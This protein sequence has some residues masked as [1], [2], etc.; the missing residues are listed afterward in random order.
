[1]NT[2]SFP[3]YAGALT[4][5]NPYSGDSARSQEHWLNYLSNA[6]L[7]KYIADSAGCFLERTSNGNRL[8]ALA[9]EQL[10][11]LNQGVQHLNQGVHQSNQL[12]AGIYSRLVRQFEE[13]RISNVLLENIAEL[14]N[15]PDGEK[16]RHAD[17]KWGLKFCKDAIRDSDLYQDALKYLQCA[18]V[19][20]PEDYFVLRQIGIL[21]LHVPALVNLQMAADY[22]T[23]AG[24]YASVDSQ[25]DAVRIG[26]VLAKSVLRRFS[27]QPDTTA[28][29]IALFAAETYLHAAVAQYAQGN[30][31]KAVDLIKKASRL[32]PECPN[33][34]FFQAKYLAAL[35]END[36]ALAVL[37]SFRDV[38]N[39]L[40][41][42]VSVDLD[43]RGSVAALWLE[44]LPRLAKRW[45]DQ[46]I[47][48][49]QPVM[50]HA[51][52]DDMQIEFFSK[53]GTVVAW[54]NDGQATVPAGLSGVVAIAARGFHTVALK[55]DG[56]VVAWGSNNSGQTTVPAGLS[57]VVAI[58]VGRLYTVALKQDG[59][60]V[61]WG[62]N[63]DGQATVP[64]GLSGVVAIAVGGFHTVALKQ[65]GTVVAWGNND[66]G[67]TTVPADL[68]GVEAIAATG[69]H[70]VALKQDRT[71]V[72]WGFNDDGQT[73][74]PADLSG[75]VAIAATG[76]HIV[77]LKQDRTVVAWGYNGSG[78][79]TVPADLSGVVAIAAGAYHTVAL[80][81]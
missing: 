61:A 46:L 52:L 55:Q 51:G 75:V 27:D 35:G 25:P 58:A 18:E 68:S 80:F 53:G 77:A 49:N 6:S 79:T 14:L 60:V 74:V 66:D 40:I 70:T 39:E 63:S 76:N 10:G 43:L 41:T 44:E 57:G 7:A 67:Q 65:D 30:P 38:S 54:G 50:Q 28:A 62:S 15:I 37:L 3:N 24:K 23:R 13:Q 42:A 81:T 5:Y 71:V 1:M 22:L 19:A 34:R 73:T 31:T 16:K 69:N 59:T 4:F 32:D 8:L 64:A 17:I 47:K 12:L 48:F 56:T 20:L 11:E 26:H 2:P 36:E 72:A 29:D 78:Q 33:L 45:A 9:N 21:Y